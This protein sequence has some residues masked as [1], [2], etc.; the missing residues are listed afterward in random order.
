MTITIKSVEGNELHLEY[1]G[2]HT[3]QDVRLCLDCE[4]RELYCE[5]NP[6]IGNA[7]PFRHFH[8]HVQ[9]WTIP[10]LKGGAANALME[11]LVEEAEA[12]CDGYS[13][14]WDGHNH[15]A[16]FTEAAKSALEGITATLYGRQF[17]ER[18]TINMWKATD[19]YQPINAASELGITADT[20][21]EEL[22]TIAESEERSASADGHDV[23]GIRE[24][25]GE[26][27]D[28]LRAKAPRLP[29]EG[30]TWIVPPSCQGQIVVVAYAAADGYG[31][32]RIFD[33]SDRTTSF[34][35]CDLDNCGCEEDCNCWD[36]INSEPGKFTWEP[37][38]E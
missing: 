33:Q 27:R 23:E 16:D 28:E 13:S 12:I 37:C 20:T 7:I 35:R 36:P 24:Y 26:V 18:D 11:E 1:A 34:E 3:R 22:D 19:W 10:A 38:Y 25:L 5:A 2:Q 29:F 15:V 17:D 31:Y 14:E 32:R 21:N 8:G 30:L 9:T 6:E 4:R